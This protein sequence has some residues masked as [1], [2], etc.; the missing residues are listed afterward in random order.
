MVAFSC[1][2]LNTAFFLKKKTLTEVPEHAEY[3]VMRYDMMTTMTSL[4]DPVR[5][6]QNNQC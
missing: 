3:A 5:E 6:F 2:P 1:S 4:D